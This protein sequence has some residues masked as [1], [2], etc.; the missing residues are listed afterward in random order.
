MEALVQTF[1]IDWKLMLAQFINF[2][3][4]FFVLYRFALKPLMKSMAER[5]ATIAKSLEQ[6]KQIEQEVARTS[7]ESAKQIQEAKRQAA[8]VIAEAAR[9]AEL[10]RQNILKETE[11]KVVQVVAQAKEQIQSEKAQMLEEVRVEAVEAVIAATEKIIKVKI[12]E[13]ADRKL[14]SQSLKDQQK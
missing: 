8:E 2:V 11:Q 4:V 12:T 7:S 5:G 6:A 9:Q 14:I 3:I 1:H 13:A 10:K